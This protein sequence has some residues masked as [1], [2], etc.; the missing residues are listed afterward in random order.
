MIKTKSSHDISIYQYQAGGHN[1]ILN[2]KED[3][4]NFLLKPFDAN[5][6]DFY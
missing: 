1:C 3:Q 6:F 4:K 5:E 2:L